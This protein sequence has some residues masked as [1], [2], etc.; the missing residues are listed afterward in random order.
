MFSR[1]LLLSLLLASTLSWAKTEAPDPVV[2]APTDAQKRTTELVYHFFSNSRFHYSPADLDD[3]L[4][5]RLFDRYLESLDGERLF[6]TA[7]D[8]EEFSRWRTRL[9]DAILA[10]DLDPAFAIFNRYLQR[11]GEQVARN[12]AMLQGTFE[13]DSDEV[14]AYDR[15]DAPWAAGTAKLDD[16]WRKRVKNDVLRLKLAGR[17]MDAIRK[18]LDKRYANF[19]ERVR[20]LKSEDVFQTFMNA[21][22]ALLEPHTG[23]MTPRTSENFNISMSLSLEGIGAVLQRE[24]EFTVI[25]SVVPG[26]PAALSGKVKVGDR[27]SGVGQ[28]SKG[29]IVDVV[30]WRIDD[31]VAL[32]RG[33]KDSQVRIELIPAE[34]GPDAKPE[35]VVLTR[36]KVKLEEQAAKKSVLEFADGDKTRRIGVIT[37][38]TFYMDFE[39]RRKNDPDYRS[40]TRD[41]ARLLGELKT[42]KVDGVLLDLRDNGGGSL[43]EAVAL[44]GLFIDTGPV[45]QV[46]HSSGRVEVEADRDSGLVWD[47]PM[48]V[49]VNRASASASEIFAAAVQDYGRGLVIGE[50][51]YGKGT[52]Q[53]LIDLDYWTRSE[54]PTYGQLKLTV[55]QFF[56]ISGGSTQHKGVE[57]DILFPITLDADEYGESALDNA[58]PWTSIDAVPHA[59]W[60]QLQP[61]VP[62][63]KVKHDT[64]ARQDREF[65]YW[66]EDVAEYRKQRA[67]K[68]LSLNEAVRRAERDRIEAKRQ[69]RKA[70]REAAGAKDAEAEVALDDGLQA[71]ERRVVDSVAEER[72]A[73]QQDDALLREAAALLADAVA[74]LETDQA[75]LAKVFPDRAAEAAAAAE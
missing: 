17:E 29:P 37:L 12:R 11:V 3:A 73:E 56:R 67:D 70:E 59:S 43:A 6:F 40:A 14:Y 46:K 61:L 35:R 21:Y 2:L 34:A 47:G 9:D 30:G 72:K 7:A 49:L 41:V 27:V 54:T 33:P 32:I 71:D 19:G 64:R 60:A 31:V 8:I 25:R 28:G 55:A 1:V 16:L 23:Y 39:A 24:D 62:L 20:E 63:L 10:Q 15:E 48:A 42:D 13:F 53:N 74:L 18:T 65:Q 66:V 44:T 26:G 36:D 58:L 22:A 75:L 57:P 4:S 69:Q 45:V 38:P 5:Q 50:P 52:V 68:T 51:T